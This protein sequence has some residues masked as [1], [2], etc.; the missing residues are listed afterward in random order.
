MR[1][2]RLTLAYDGADLVGWQRQPSGTSVQALVEDVLAILD[3]QP[4]TITGAGR[5][6]AGVHALGQVASFSL[7]RDIAP[8]TLVRALNFHLPPSVRAVEAA[9]VPPQFHARFSAKSKTYRYQIWTGPVHPPMIRSF[10]WHVPGPLD[11]EAMDSAARRLEG[12]HDFAAFQSVGTEVPD[13]ERTIMSSHVQTGASDR[14]G[15]LGGLTT[16]AGRLVTYEVTGSG[17]LR[18]MVRGIVGTLV[19]IGLG[20]HNPGWINTVLESRD[21]AEAGRNA[22]PQGLFLVRVT[23]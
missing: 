18:H 12:L 20:R 1:Q 6:D 16:S 5:T 4:V 11:V 23:Y 21:R 2:F 3:G 17:F 19:E 10:S 14:P 15:V 13:T 7:A 8:D 22:P 9:E